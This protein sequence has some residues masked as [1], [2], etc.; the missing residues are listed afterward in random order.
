MAS[1][2]PAARLT[3]FHIESL[4]SVKSKSD[5]GLRSSETNSRAI[6]HHS[7]CAKKEKAS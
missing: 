6:S 3:D 2:M 1:V 4:A 7:T 5:A